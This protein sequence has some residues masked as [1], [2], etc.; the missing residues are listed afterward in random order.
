M[1]IVIP[2][3]L[4]PGSAIP[5]SRQLRGGNRNSYMENL[6]RSGFELIALLVELDRRG[7]D[8]DVVVRKKR[9]RPSNVSM[10]L[11]KQGGLL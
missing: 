2:K 11:S 8:A 6:E 10:F 5:I 4:A 1:V 9:G 7:F 3:N